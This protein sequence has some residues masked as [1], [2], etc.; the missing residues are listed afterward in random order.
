MAETGVLP[1]PQQEEPPALS[2][3]TPYTK[4][5]EAAI[6]KFYKKRAKDPGAYGYDE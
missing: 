2:E 4:E 5:A 3:L 6:K 1:K